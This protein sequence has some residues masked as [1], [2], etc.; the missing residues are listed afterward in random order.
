MSTEETTPGPDQGG[1]GTSPQTSLSLL[2]RARAREQTAWDRLFYLYRPLVLYWCARWGVRHEDADDVVQEVFRE[3][4]DSLPTFEEGRPGATFRGW[5]R[6]VTRNRLL[7]HFRQA[8]KHAPG[9]AGRRP[10]TVW[11]T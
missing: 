1:R 5:L 9:R 7:M 2:Y 11:S 10:C 6:G 4:S 8:G 3:V